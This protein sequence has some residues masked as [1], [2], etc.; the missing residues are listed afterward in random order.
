MLTIFKLASPLDGAFLPLPAALGTHLPH[1]AQGVAQPQ[2]PFGAALK[3][4]KKL[5]KIGPLR[6]HLKEIHA[7]ILQPLPQA[8]QQH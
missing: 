8:G 5:V 3:F 6:K 2:L 1:P 7:V 4:P